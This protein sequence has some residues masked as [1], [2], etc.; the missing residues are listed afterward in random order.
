MIPGDTDS[1]VGAADDVCSLLT[2]MS[3]D[4]MLIARSPVSSIGSENFGALCSPLL[5]ENDDSTVN[6]LIVDDTPFNRFA[7]LNLMQKAVPNLQATE[8]GSGMEAI[9]IVEH[10]SHLDAMFDFIL[11]DIAMPEMTGWETTEK[12]CEMEKAGEIGTLC[13]IVAHTAFSA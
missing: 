3:H 2:E 1:E 10:I 5:V 12:L 4:E 7:I 6:V 9:A 13:P 8:A 11:M